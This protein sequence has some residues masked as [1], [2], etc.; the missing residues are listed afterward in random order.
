MFVYL[1]RVCKIFQAYSWYWVAAFLALLVCLLICA[2]SFVI[3]ANSFI[4]KKTSF[5]KYKDEADPG[6]MCYNQYAFVKSDKRKS[7]MAVWSGET[8]ENRQTTGIEDK[9]DKMGGDHGG[10]NQ[11]RCP[12]HLNTNLHTWMEDSRDD[13]NSLVAAKT[14]KL[15][16]WCCYVSSAFT[17][18]VSWA[19]MS[20]ASN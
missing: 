8:V 15:K 2:S 9:E 3:S 11:F 5:M 16:W 20:Y 12:S 13:K 10:R 18:D 19:A 7:T 14:D 1:H 6:N 4:C 17:R